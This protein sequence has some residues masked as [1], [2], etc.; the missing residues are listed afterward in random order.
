MAPRA[1][2]SAKL[3]ALKFT[4]LR[5]SR[6]R[7]PTHWLMHSVSLLHYLA[8]TIVMVAEAPCGSASTTSEQ[9]R[10]RRRALCARRAFL[11]TPASFVVTWRDDARRGFYRSKAGKQ[12]P[13][14]EAPAT[15]VG[16]LEREI[17]ACDSSREHIGRMR[18]HFT[19]RFRSHSKAR[20]AR[21]ASAKTKTLPMNSM[22]RLRRDRR[23]HRLERRRRRCRR[24]KWS[25]TS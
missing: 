19:A 5:R 8:A 13:A 1:A 23:C 17:G 3:T 18:L 15:A 11:H 10:S 12:H 7:P 6:K 22:T 25:V 2:A 20:T 21:I 16:Q 24:G 14:R 4:G 9:R